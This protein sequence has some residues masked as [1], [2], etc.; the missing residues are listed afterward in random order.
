MAGFKRRVLAADDVTAG[1]ALS[2]LPHPRRRQSDQVGD[3]GDAAALSAYSLR[4][5][6]PLDPKTG[7][8]GH[9]ALISFGISSQT[10][11]E[12]QQ[13]LEQRPRPDRQARRRGSRSASPACR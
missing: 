11:A 13:L 12:Q 7:K 9:V 3:R 5:V 6:A 4:Q 8:L 1:P 10:L 2:R